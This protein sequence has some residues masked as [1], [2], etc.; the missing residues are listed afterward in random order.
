MSTSVYLVMDLINDLVHE[1]GPNG[2]Q[3]LGQEVRRRRVLENTAA[4]LAKARQASVRIG[5]VRVGFSSDYREISPTSPLFQPLKGSGV[6]RL[7][8][9]GTQVHDAVAPRP[10]DFDIVKHRVSPFYGTRLELLLRAWGVRRLYLSGVST[11][12]VVTSTVREGHDRDFE[13]VVLE[14]CCSAA[15]QAEH[16]AAI[17][18]F[19]PLCAEITTS[20][21]VSFVH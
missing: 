9:W 11:N 1:N 3:P 21:K 16:D 12:F 2:N 7:N 10:E 17:S 18:G 14:D 15:S 19:R 8:E 4:A 5:Y 13:I 6:L 20:A